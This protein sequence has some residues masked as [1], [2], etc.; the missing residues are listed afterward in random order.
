MTFRMRW[1]LSHIAWRQA[2]CLAWSLWAALAAT[3]SAYAIDA[4]VWEAGEIHSG[5]LRATNVSVR[6]DLLSDTRTRASVRAREVQAPAPVGTLTRVRFTCDNP[7]I[8]EPTFGC[9]AGRLSARGGPTGVIE[10]RLRGAF[11]SDTGTARLTI[12]GLPLADGRVSLDATNSASGWHVSGRIGK[13]T[14]AAV[15]Q[16]VAPWFK[17]P[18][19]ITLDGVIESEFA[20]RGTGTALRAASLTA[21]LGAVNFSNAEGTTAGE[22]LTA[23]FVA[24]LGHGALEDAVQIRLT[25]A[26]GQALAGPVLL[27]LTNNP[28]EIDASGTLRDKRLTIGKLTILQRDLLR[29]AGTGAIDFSG[30]TPLVNA[31]LMIEELKFPAAYSSFA[32]IALASSDFGDLITS[33]SVTGS[34]V[35]VDNA[36]RAATLHLSDVDLV[37][38]RGKLRV[39]D[40]GGTVHWVAAPD[41][42]VSESTVQWSGGGAYGLSGGAAQLSF[43]ARAAG[44]ELTRPA[45]LPVFDGGIS[46]G[47]LA[48]RNLG[49]PNLEI[50]F[51]ANVEPISMPLLCKAF[52][53]PEFAGKVA[54][55]IPNLT[56]RK[57]LLAVGGDIEARVFGG[58][59]V[60]SNLRLQDPFG[61]WPRMFADVRARDLD[62]ALLTSTF[63][64]GTITG[65]LEADVLGLELFAWSPV[66]FNARLATPNGDR[67]SKRISAKAVGNLSNIGGGGGNV[68]KALQSG[69]LK[70]FDDYSY[71]R[72][73]LT[74]RLRDNVCVMS[75]VEPAGVGYY[76]VQGSGI[77][78]IDIIG[79]SG[80]VDWRQL[81]TQ[82][83]SAINARSEDVEVK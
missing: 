56:Y 76:I 16:F 63:A 38:R 59:V 81:V 61:P 82:I 27:D 55:R 72:L 78:R 15:R 64:V 28:L 30:N 34:A 40:I 33:G 6:L 42:A 51:E 26:A 48:L 37:D 52:G 24:L 35:I 74:C 20:A 80:R 79:N 36:P 23:K 73:G 67:S 83:S 1:L 69:A 62:L 19:E 44:I 18:A 70:F 68:M 22:N 7:T 50:D 5:E 71:Q 65:R 32:Q 10:A 53:W 43:K 9:P 17:V 21:E 4:L 29:A 13:A 2:R 41:A 77:P 60:G 11:V 66:A 47:K 49:S 8:R 25:S 58:T 14:L 12:S 54:G 31:T 46:I 45:R 39:N 75:G 57:K 3:P